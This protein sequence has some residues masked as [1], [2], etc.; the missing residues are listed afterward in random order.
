MADR[1]KVVYKFK[2]PRNPN[3]RAKHRLEF[4][5]TRDLTVRD[6]ERLSDEEHEAVKSAVM[7]NGNKLYA[8][9]GGR[10]KKKVDSDAADSDVPADSDADDEGAADDEEVDDDE[11]SEESTLN[12][13]A[14]LHTIAV[15]EAPDGDG[16]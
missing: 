16:E 3:G 8:S 2:S 9:V 1:N 4:V 6:V 11:A 15:S 7:P 5:P 14:G 10:K 13:G 12:V